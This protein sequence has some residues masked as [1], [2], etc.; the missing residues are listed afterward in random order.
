MTTLAELKAAAPELPW[1]EASVGTEVWFG[2][3]MP[4]GI[5][6]YQTDRTPVAEAVRDA[7]MMAA[8]VTPKPL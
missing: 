7:R 8:T 2:V 4:D 3:P 5:L 1:I 6:Y